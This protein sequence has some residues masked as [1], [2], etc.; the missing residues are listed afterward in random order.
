MKRRVLRFALSPFVA[1]AA[2]LWLVVDFIS[3]PPDAG[4]KTMLETTS[5]TRSRAHGNRL[6]EGGIF[7][8]DGAIQLLY[9]DFVYDPDDPSCVGSVLAGARLHPHGWWAPTSESY[10]ATLMTSYWQPVTP[11]EIQQVREQFAAHFE[12]SGDPFLTEYGRAIR[13]NLGVVSRPTPSGYF[14]NS[15]ALLCALLLV[16]QG[17]RASF[18]AMGAYRASK[19]IKRGLC[20]KCAYPVGT[21]TACTECGAAVNR[22]AR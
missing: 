12:A 19:R 6:A 4:V 15:L 18:V 16:A 22:I 1:A 2:A 3:L 21:S 7:R 8:R 17:C 5:Q 14:R 9:E 13:Q 10:N 20:P 11:S